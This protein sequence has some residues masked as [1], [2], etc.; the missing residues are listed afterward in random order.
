M[1]TRS[2]QPPTPRETGA[3]TRVANRTVVS[4]PDRVIQIERVTVSREQQSSVAAAI[5]AG[6]STNASE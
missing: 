6:R 1:T 5:R 2:Q 3:P 4:Q